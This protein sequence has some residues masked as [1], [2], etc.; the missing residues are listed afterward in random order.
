MISSI[1]NLVIKFSNYI[2]K[3]NFLKSITNYTIKQLFVLLFDRAVNCWRNRSNAFLKQQN[4]FNKLFII[5][6]QSILKEKK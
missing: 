5:I 3:K 6:I 2:K 4:R 1:D